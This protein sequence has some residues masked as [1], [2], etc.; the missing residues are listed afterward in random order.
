MAAILKPSEMSDTDFVLKI[1]EKSGDRVDPGEKFH[2]EHNGIKSDQIE[3]GVL[4]CMD[5]HTERHH[6]KKCNDV[7]EYCRKYLI[8]LYGESIYSK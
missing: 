3:Y 4:L 7:K 1:N 5:C 6:G 2:H 8:N